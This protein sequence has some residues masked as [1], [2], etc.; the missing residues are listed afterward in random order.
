M[1]P[2]VTK[3]F[4]QRTSDAVDGD[5]DDLAAD[6]VVSPRVVVRRVLLPRDQLLRVEQ[7]PVRPRSNLEPQGSLLDEPF[8]S[9]HNERG[10]SPHI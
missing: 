7:R 6:G 4:G 5:V 2:V 8:D 10:I 3:S 9:A 1:D